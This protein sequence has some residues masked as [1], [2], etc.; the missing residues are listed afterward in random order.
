MFRELTLTHQCR[1][2]F[3]SIKFVNEFVD[4]MCMANPSLKPM[5]RTENGKKALHLRV[6]KAIYGCVESSLL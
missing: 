6:L 1:R 4:L 5:V 2:I 3:I